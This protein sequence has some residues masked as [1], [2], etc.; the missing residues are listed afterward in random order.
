M[1]STGCFNNGVLF[2]NTVGMG[3]YGWWQY[4]LIYR[5]ID[6]FPLCW[7]PV[8]TKWTDNFQSILELKTYWKWDFVG[9]TDRANIISLC[10][11]E[12]LICSGVSGPLTLLLLYVNSPG[13]WSSFFGVFPHSTIVY[14]SPTEC[15]RRAL[16]INLYVVGGKKKKKK[17]K[18]WRWKTNICRCAAQWSTQGGFM[19]KKLIWGEKKCAG[20]A[21]RGPDFKS[22]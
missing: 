19:G 12:L 17:E 15:S 13:F 22:C 21:E 11:Q 18:K 9:L 5:D 10:V 6:E 14:F 7:S 20:V 1:S 4:V 16:R 3:F 2:K 8:V